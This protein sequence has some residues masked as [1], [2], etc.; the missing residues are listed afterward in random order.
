MTL[1]ARPFAVLTRIVLPLMLP[2]MFAGGII[3]FSLSFDEF[4]I[5][6]LLA[7]GPST[8][9]PVQLFQYM[10]FSVS[11][12][13]AAISTI[14]ILATLLILI[15]FHRVAGIETLFGSRRPRT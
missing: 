7:Q 5:S 8:T 4:V 1:G 11:P 13:V 3:A 9:F 10:R 14:L 12:I 6:V 2:G 15:V